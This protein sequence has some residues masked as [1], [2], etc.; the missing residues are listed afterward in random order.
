LITNRSHFAELDAA[1]VPLKTTPLSRVVILADESAN[2]RVAGLRQLDRLVLC[3]D[4]FAK[5]EPLDLTPPAPK[6]K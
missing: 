1:R 4:E 6:K 5:A 2:W 3:L